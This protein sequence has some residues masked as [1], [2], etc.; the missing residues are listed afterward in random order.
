MKKALIG[1]VTAT[2]LAC[3]LIQI[4]PDVRRYLRMVRM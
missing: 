1:G 2:A 4:F 3:V